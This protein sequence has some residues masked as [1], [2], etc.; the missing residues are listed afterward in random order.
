VCTMIEKLRLPYLVASRMT[1]W[2]MFWEYSHDSNTK[3]GR[4]LKIWW[5]RWE[6]GTSLVDLASC[7]GGLFFGRFVN[8]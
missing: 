6:M 5:L 8:V 4:G 7:H 3:E 1:Q 2:G